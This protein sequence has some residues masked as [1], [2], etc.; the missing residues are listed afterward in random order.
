VAAANAAFGAIHA[1]LAIDDVLN[2]LILTQ[3]IYK[4]ILGGPSSILHRPER[5]P[6]F[7]EF[8]ESD[9]EGV[10]GAPMFEGTQPATQVRLWTFQTVCL[11]SSPLPR[12]VSIFE[13]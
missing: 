13:I 5:C 6:F 12:F 4:F 7:L 11:P 8:T 3:H 1:R 10:G 2:A 9:G